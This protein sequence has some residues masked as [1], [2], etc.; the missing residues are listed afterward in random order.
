MVNQL[1]L[2]RVMAQIF[3]NRNSTHKVGVYD[4]QRCKDDKYRFILTKTSDSISRLKH[5]V[6]IN[7]ACAK[8]YT[9]LQN[10][11][12]SANKAGCKDETYRLLPNDIYTIMV[13]MAHSPQRQKKACKLGVGCV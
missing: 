11:F 1:I 5:G 10:L 8:D 13:I 12:I 3:A 4:F 6:D 7:H 2:P 9:L